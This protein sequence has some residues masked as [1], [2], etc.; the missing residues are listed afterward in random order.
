MTLHQSH[1]NEQEQICHVLVYLHATFE[2]NS[3][4]IVQDI[5]SLKVVKFE[6]HL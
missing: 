6:T 5:A 1:Q 3:L 4:N 2:C